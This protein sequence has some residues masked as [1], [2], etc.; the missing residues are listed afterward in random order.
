M[1]TTLPQEPRRS[2]PAVFIGFMMTLV[3]IFMLAVGIYAIY[4]TFQFSR[5]G[6]PLTAEVTAMEITQDE[7]PVYNVYARYTVNGQEYSKRYYVRQDEYAFSYVG[8]T[9][10]IEVLADN[11]AESRLA[12]EIPWVTMLMPLACGAIAA[13]LGVLFMMARVVPDDSDA[14][15][16]VTPDSSPLPG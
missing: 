13:P 15:K 8:G 3:G 9:L 2:I 12:G 6:E 1:T 5:A 4:L 10:A 7:G 16:D 11:P 14:E